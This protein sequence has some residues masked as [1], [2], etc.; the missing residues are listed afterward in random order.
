MAASTRAPNR[1]LE[2][3]DRVDPREAR[4]FRAHATPQGLCD[5]LIN[6]LKLL[7]NQQKD[8][9]TPV[10]HIVTVWREKS[11]KGIMDAL[12]KFIAVDNY[13]AVKVGGPQQDTTSLRLVKPKFTTDVP[14]ATSE[15]VW[16]SSQ[17]WA[18]QV[19]AD[20]H[21]FCQAIF[22]G[23]EGQE[24]EAMYYHFQGL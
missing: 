3:Q 18:P 12:R 22:Q 13:E 21:V 14:G 7:T 4:V 20:S 9:D 5:S 19:D 8:G 2:I 23:I 24:W 16:T 1:L 6:S 15:N 11:R 10:E 17:W